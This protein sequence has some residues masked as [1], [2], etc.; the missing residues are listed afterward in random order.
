MAPQ[1]NV[2]QM[3][4]TSHLQVIFDNFV[5][6]LIKEKILVKENNKKL[7]LSLAQLKTIYNIHCKYNEVSHEYLEA[8]FM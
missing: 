8:F 3:L 5:K 6:F 7:N 2:A 4:D 1:Q